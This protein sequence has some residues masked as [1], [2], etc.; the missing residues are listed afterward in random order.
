M[1][2]I[3]RG[4]TWI[5]EPTVGNEP[6]VSQQWASEARSVPAAVSRDA[7]ALRSGA[8]VRL[9]AAFFRLPPSLNSPVPIDPSTKLNQQ[10]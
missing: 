2:S 7:K 9:E 3:G 6:E 5:G 8:S 10:Y 1:C 4:F